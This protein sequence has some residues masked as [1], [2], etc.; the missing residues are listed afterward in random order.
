M[1]KKI[2]ISFIS[3]LII[4]G[5]VA[6][7]SAYEAHVINVTAHIENALAVSPKEIAFGTVFPQEYVDNNFTISLSDS[8]QGSGRYDDVEYVINQKPKCKCDVWNETPEKCPN[9]KYA[10]VGYA[11]HICPTGYTA[12]ADLCPFLS[13]LPQENDGEI[14]EP[15]YY[16]PETKTCPARLTVQPSGH[17]AKSL[18]DLSDTWT[19][20]LKVPPIAGT[21]GQDWPATCPT[22]ATEADYGCDLWVEVTGLSTIEQYPE[23]GTA[24]IGYE[25]WWNGDFDYNDFGMN[26]VAKEY[27]NN[28]GGSDY[29]SEN[30][31]NFTAV[32][33][34]SGADHYIHIKRPYSGTY[35]YTVSR[36]VPASTGE[37]PAGTYTGSGT[38]DIVLFNTAKYS[39]PQ[40]NIGEIVTVDVK[41]DNP[42]L[43]PK[44]A[45][46][47]PRPDINPFMANYDPWE[48]PYTNVSGNFH[49]TDTEVISS[50]TH[51]QNTP[52][53]IPAGTELPFILVIPATNWRTPHED[54]TITSP[55]W[56]FQDY[57]DSTMPNWGPAWPNWYTDIDPTHNFVGFGGLAF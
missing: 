3:V 20:D 36:S 29:L 13:K 40:I 54:T 48:N 12:M 33:Y 10:P 24:Y 43:N 55:Y 9:G 39:L 41:L 32:I 56:H 23:T 16:D 5:G 6:T 15:S 52:R 51:Q 47:A 14:G 1:T 25:D 31:M 46:G 7:M 44:A 50:T 27:Y 37:K 35:T 21:V 26:F 2:I 4:A 57:Y 45:L 19:V 28:I 17:L 38:L 34:D 11:T 53:I 22:V 30:I 18:N 8:F 49:L 42:L